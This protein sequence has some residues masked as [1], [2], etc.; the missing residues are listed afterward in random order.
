MDK[1]AALGSRFDLLSRWLILAIYMLLP[2]LFAFLVMGPWANQLSSLQWRVAIFALFTLVGTCCARK[3]PQ[4]IAVL[5]WKK[6]LGI[7]A[8]F[9]GIVYKLATFLPDVS[10]YPWSLG[11]SEVSRYYY[12]S[13]FFARQTY[14]MDTPPSVLH[15][16][17]YLMQSLPF[18]IPGLP[19]WFH[20]LWQVFLWFGMSLITGLAYRHRVGGG[21]AFVMW[22]ILSLFI[23][24]VYYHLLVMVFLVM[25]WANTGRFGR[26][27]V[28]VFVASVWAGI[29]RVNWL[30]VPGLLAAVLYFLEIPIQEKSWWKYLL[31]PIVWT[32]TGSIIGLLTQ[33]LYVLLSGN[34]VEQFGSSFSSEL[35]W[36]RLFPNATYP[37]GVLPASL[38][39]SLPGLFVIGAFFL[40]RLR[41]YSAWR[42]L[43]LASILSV[44]LTMGVLVSLKIGGGSNLHNLDAYL[45]VLYAIGAYLYCDHFVPDKKTTQPFHPTVWLSLIVWLLPLGFTL[46]AGGPLPHYDL[47]RANRDLATVITELEKASQ[48]GEVLLITQRHLLALGWADNVRLVPDYEVVFLME[49]AMSGNRPYLDN[50]E[51]D[52][53]S[54]RYSLILSEPFSLQLQGQYHSFGEENDAWVSNVSDV[55]LCYYEPMQDFPEYNVQLFAP[56]LDPCIR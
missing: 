33:Q 49:M 17:R 14:G 15:P 46:S 12:A 56:R 3:L 24:P 18:L 55:V 53:K 36:Y 50:F 1:D 25:W 13:L 32:V 45:I 30:P 23:G 27:F 20:R 21:W 10:T 6:A 43:G 39:V 7:T 5:N 2:V 47:Q 28:V 26:T 37:L 16:S 31:P 44:L 34:P 4:R 40:K 41:Y 38:L 22:I 42:L 11:W 35:L 19:L 48:D 52:L 54:Q 8:L 29:S 9:Y 51:K